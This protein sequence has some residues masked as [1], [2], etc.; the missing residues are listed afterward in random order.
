MARA[1]MQA[2]MGTVPQ[3]PCLCSHTQVLPRIRTA[4]L[5]QRVKG[6]VS[7]ST[8]MSIVGWVQL[9]GWGSHARGRRGVFITLIIMVA[10][11]QLFII[12][13]SCLVPLVIQEPMVGGD[14]PGR[15]K[16][17]QLLGLTTQA[18][19]QDAWRCCAPPPAAQVSP[20]MPLFTPYSVGGGSQFHQ[21][22]RVWGPQ[23]RT[24]PVHLGICHGLTGVPTASPVPSGP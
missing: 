13:L 18:T 11:L 2:H 5:A 16:A 6:L 1:S 14:R 9:V 15:E 19:V 24:P 10:R 8:H 7:G 3:Q 23:L 17:C 20:T 12:V 4:H 21:R 22:A